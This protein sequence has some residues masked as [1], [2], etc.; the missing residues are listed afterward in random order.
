MAVLRRQWRVSL[1]VIAIAVGIFL[2]W[3]RKIEGHT[4]GNG[5]IWVP[6]TFASLD[7]GIHDA[8]PTVGKVK[9]DGSLTITAGG[10]ITCKDPA[11]PAGDSACDIDL[12]VTGTLEIQGGGSI[13][14]QNLVGG[15]HGGAIHIVV[16]GDF[17]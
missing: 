17:I 9:I 2:L 10:S 12:T 4:Q 8:D 14:T 6:T 15:G 5:L 3:G 16:G 11:A 1:L 7:N 13:D